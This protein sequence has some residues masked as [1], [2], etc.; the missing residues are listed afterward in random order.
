MQEI[1]AVSDNVRRPVETVRI[2]QTGRPV[3]HLAHC[4]R[5]RRPGSRTSPRLHP[6]VTMERPINTRS[7]GVPVERPSIDA[8]HQLDEVCSLLRQ[9]DIRIVSF[10]GAAAETRSRLAEAV[11]A[12]MESELACGVVLVDLARVRQQSAIGHVLAEAM[13]DGSAAAVPLLNEVA[14]WLRAKR[15]LLIVDNVANLSD[16]GRSVAHLLKECPRLRVL[17]TSPLVV[18]IEGEQRF[19]VRL[20]P[21]ESHEQPIRS[22][23]AVSTR[24]LPQR[25]EG[26]RALVQQLSSGGSLQPGLVP[27]ETELPPLTTREQEV[28]QLLA[29]GFSN[30]DIARQLVITYRTAETHACRV[31]QKLGFNCRGFVVQWALECGL[32]VVTCRQS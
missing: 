23:P 3:E 29:L 8:C 2:T 7:T 21:S 4:G 27:G 20:P 11:A 12:V 9:P 13:R 14:A 1:D 28:A 18:Q 32:V 5:P 30:K 10:R 6:A 16:G 31:L 24:V 19:M 17:L 15:T 26:G 25:V 22:A